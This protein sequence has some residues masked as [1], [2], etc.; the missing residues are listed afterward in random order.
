MAKIITNKSYQRKN[1]VKGSL[2]VVAALILSSCAN[3]IPLTKTSSKQAPKQVV[4][5]TPADAKALP[6]LPKVK[7]A[8]P[9][10]VDWQKIEKLANSYSYY[11]NHPEYFIKSQSAIDLTKD[12]SP[13]EMVEKSYAKA[14]GLTPSEARKRLTLQSISRGVIDA[15]EQVLGDDLVEVYYVN[16]NPD[17]F[18]LGVT[19]THAVKASSYLY[20][21]KDSAEQLTLPIYIYPIS[22]KTKAQILQLMEK[23]HPEITKRYPNT[24]SI[25]YEPITNSVIVDLY[26]EPIKRPTPE[27]TY[28]IKEELTKLVGHPVTVETMT[29]QITVN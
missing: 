6:A 2:L 9:M 28:A 7:P 18:Q 4:Q 1:A 11:K 19:A 26:F 20:T 13:I 5:P 8:A 10:A 12:T 24:Q 14:F 29:G 21:F 22:D 15:L 25:G 27:Q 17:E 23:A 16:N 3:T